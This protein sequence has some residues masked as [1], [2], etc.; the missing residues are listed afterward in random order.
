[1]RIQYFAYG[2][3]IGVGGLAAKGLHAD[4]SVAGRLRG[5]QLRFDVPSAFRRLEGGVANIVETG[6]AADYVLGTVHILDGD[7]VPILDS[8][9]AAGYLYERRL[10]E[11]EDA[12]I[13][14]APAQ[15]YVGLPG[16]RDAALRPS[17]RYLKI[18]LDGAVE[19]GFPS[20]YVD[21]LRAVETHTPPSDEPFEVTD[22]S[23]DTLDAGALAQH[24]EWVALYGVVFDLS[25][26]RPEH[27]FITNLYG[28]QDATP[29][30][31]SMITGGQVPKGPIDPQL[32]GYLNALQRELACDY[33][34]VALYASR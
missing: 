14:D 16:V 15:A 30:A 6:D 9:E 18:M 5:W 28:G 23:L 31:V 22:R 1:M 34:I 32:A 12:G 20:S 19:R 25:R 21:W 10:V 26:P 2:S 7:A 29:P 33:P 11:L 4:K 27:A 17:A 24:A 13:A 8:I 3:N